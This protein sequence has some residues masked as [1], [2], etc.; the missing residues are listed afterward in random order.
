MRTAIQRAVRVAFETHRLDALAAPTLPRTTLPVEKLA[1]ELTRSGGADELAGAVRSLVG[2][3]VVGLPAISVPCGAA[4]GLPIGLHLAARP[5][6]E[7][8]LLRLAY[9][10]EQATPWHERRPELFAAA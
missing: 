10:Y 2:A 8:D 4:D 3:N 5:L 7:G 6:A 1:V 9:A